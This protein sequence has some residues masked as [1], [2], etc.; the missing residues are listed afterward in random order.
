MGLAPGKSLIRCAIQCPRHNRAAAGREDLRGGMER[1]F[2]APKQAENGRAAARHRRLRGARPSERRDNLCNLGMASRD[3]RSPS[4]STNFK[5]SDLPPRSRTAF[6][7]A[8]GRGSLASAAL[9][10]NNARVVSSILILL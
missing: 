9:A 5:N 8:S 4:D 2:L 10:E 6:S 3:D 1:R 7:M